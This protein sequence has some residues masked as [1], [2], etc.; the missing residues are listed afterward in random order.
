MKNI[1][2]DKSLVDKISAGLE[3]SYQKL[4]ADKRKRGEYLV[5]FR[6]GKIM[7]IKP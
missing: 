6:D 7:R 5:V 1:D 4:L 3:L 2:N